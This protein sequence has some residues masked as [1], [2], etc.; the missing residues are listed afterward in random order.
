MSTES[1]KNYHDKIR[2]EISKII[3]E[4]IKINEESR[5]LAA[6]TLEIARKTWWHPWLAVPVAIAAIITPIILLIDHIPK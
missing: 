2:A 4:S 6:E 3:A 5:K 1:D